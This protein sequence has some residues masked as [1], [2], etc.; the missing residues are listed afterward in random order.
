[1]FFPAL[2]ATA[3]ACL[4]SIAAAAPSL[5]RVTQPT[6]HT[7][8]TRCAGAPGKPFVDYTMGC[9]DTGP[10]FKCGP[11]PDYRSDPEKNWGKFCLETDAK[12]KPAA[13]VLAAGGAVTFPVKFKQPLLPDIYTADPSAHVIDGKLY[14]FCSADDPKENYK[15]PNE[16]HFL[17]TRYR[18][19]SFND[20]L[21]QVTNNGDILPLTSVP[22]ADK[23]LWAPDATCKDHKCIL[24][25]PAKAKDGKFRIG[26]AISASGPAG[27]YE[28]QQNYMEG[29]YSVD[30]AVFDDDDGS[31]WMVWGGEW[32]GQLENWPN[33]EWDAGAQRPTS[34]PCMLPRIAKLKADMLEI[35]DVQKIPIVDSDGK[36]IQASDFDRKFFEAPWIHKVRSKYYLSYSTGQSHLLVYATAEKIAGPYTF[37][38]KLLSP[39]EGWTT[40]HSI[41][42]YKDKT[43]LFYHDSVS[44]GETNLRQ[45]KFQPLEY[46]AGGRI[47]PMS[48]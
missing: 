39:P 14:V 36:E 28:A 41:V 15:D 6:C 17:M 22:W 4:L 20:D 33:N 13:A 44:S 11:H 2:T 19:M 27:P 16:M 31:R 12:G 30:P 42:Q 46:E 32:G 9:C 5:H 45:V 34:G 7:L 43:Y 23:Q 29:T 24:Y 3:C 47:K 37:Q 48:P 26:A 1:M 10:S 8:H 38:G 25:F 21:S 40:H 18:I 35:E